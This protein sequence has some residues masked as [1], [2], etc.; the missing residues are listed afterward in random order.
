M[1][2]PVLRS[3]NGKN[4]VF[5]VADCHHISENSTPPSHKLCTL[6]KKYHDKLANANVSQLDAVM[7]DFTT[8]LN[9]EM[10]LSSSFSDSDY[11]SSFS[12]LTVNEGVATVTN[13]GNTSAFLMRNGQLTKLTNIKKHAFSA[14]TPKNII[15]NFA[16]GEVVTPELSDSYEITK[17]DV[18]LLCSDGLTNALNDSRISYI[19]S[20]DLSDERLAT[21]LIS[22]A[23][24]RGSS[25]DVTVMIIRNGAPAHKS[26]EKVK[27][28]LSLS[29]GAIVLAVILAFILSAFSS[30]QKPEISQ[31]NTVPVQTTTPEPDEFMT[32]EGNSDDDDFILRTQKPQ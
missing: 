17:N 1:A 20:L 25:D 2:K 6:L 12:M 27:T 22:E 14:H 15:G 3:V 28:L 23:I 8:D 30:C 5:A 24:A 7:R 31:E 32:S 4:L 21:R 10:R 19:L 13:I 9:G 11:A 16:S 29:I 18:F 26:P